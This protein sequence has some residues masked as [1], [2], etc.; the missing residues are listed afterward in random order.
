[1]ASATATG[2]PETDRPLTGRV[3]LPLAGSRLGRL[4]LLL[5]I[6]GLV[7]L[8]AGALIMNEFTRGLVEA[9]LDSLSTQGQLLSYAI[10]NAATEGDPEP[11]MNPE[12]GRKILTLLGVPPSER[13]RLY[14]ADGHL[15]A[16]T[17]LIADRVLQRNLPAV[18]TPGN[19]LSESETAV[20]AREAKAH[21]AEMAE[22]QAAL[23]GVKVSQV[24]E[25]ESGGR[26]VSVSIPIQHVQRVLG[27]LML[28]AGGVD[29]IVAAQ[30]RTLT[31]FIIIA[32]L[33]TLVSSIL[34]DQLVARPVLRL[35]RAADSVRLSRA[36]AMSLPDL[37]GRDDEVGDL[38][39]SLESMTQTQ[40]ARLDAIERFAADV[41]HEIKNPLTSIR[42][43][44]E[45]LEMAPAASPV[46]DRLIGILKSDVRRMDRLITD[47]SNAS[48]V[49]AELSR[50]APRGVELDRLLSD[51][52]A[53]YA[54][55]LHPD[56]PSVRLILP[57]DSAGLWVSGRETPF[58]QVFR[59]L[60]DNAR[61]FSPRD[62][63]VRVTLSRTA[64]DKTGRGR[65]VVFVDDD[66]PG[67]PTDNLET[68]FQRF[69]TSRP[70]GQAFGSHSGLGLS[71]ARQ[72]V[73]AHGGVIRAIN[74][75]G[76]QGQVLGARF[77]VDLP[78]VRA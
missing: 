15:I 37:A 34:L 64:P 29:A 38:T 63:E 66:G 58:G 62:G 35:A 65:I 10:V 8:I 59:N 76:D 12:L 50:E 70:R 69:Y 6:L 51:I 43:A 36:R 32:V 54:A 4:I 11:S 71:I 17:D 74:R 13:A 44:V 31:P 9:R 23:K 16:D 30:R 52:V 1:M 26:L 14:D 41:A 48:R 47:I 25:S 21:G 18:R 2:N 77:S 75:E 3:R 67:V 22:V 72:I 45:T 7:V 68:V 28:E 5:N 24:R 46:R 42:S 61:S 60:I 57:A 55:E 49:D 73:E 40:S 19:P 56:E 33:V 20:S 78:E 53:T 39:R 27:V